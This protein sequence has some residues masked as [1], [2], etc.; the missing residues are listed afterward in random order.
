MPNLKAHEL[1]QIAGRQLAYP[2]PVTFL[3]EPALWVFSERVG[4]MNQALAIVWHFPAAVAYL[5]LKF[6]QRLPRPLHSLD[7]RII[8]HLDS[9]L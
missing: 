1:R 2:F 6:P 4:Y 5:C 8:L 7:P 9:L 3:A